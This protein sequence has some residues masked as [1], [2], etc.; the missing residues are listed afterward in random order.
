MS[1]KDLDVQIDLVGGDG[2]DDLAHPDEISE[3]TLD[4]EK[5][6]AKVREILFG[7]N[8]RGLNRD[9]N[10][11]SES[12]GAKFDAFMDDQNQRMSSLEERIFERLDEVSSK[13]DGEK[14]QRRKSS[15]SLE[16][17]LSALQNRLT[18]EIDDVKRQSQEVNS[19]LK[20]FI[21]AE[22]LALRETLA[23]HR[24]EMDRQI[25]NSVSEMESKKTDRL[26]LSDILGE[27]SKR[28][29]DEQDS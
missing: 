29:V 4:G 21:D 25:K 10:S 5:N 18:C 12:I 13:L 9:I 26:A 2:L 8:F 1:D 16:S 6:L 22:T 17:S 23:S 28:L 7:P 19:G 11:L 27:M 3:N 14:D 20:E 15:T 24:N